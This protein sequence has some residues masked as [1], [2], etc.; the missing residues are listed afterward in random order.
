MVHRLLKFWNIFLPW[1]LKL[2]GQ[3]FLPPGRR[4]VDSPKDI[5][6]FPPFCGRRVVAKGDQFYLP[7]ADT[8]RISAK[9]VFWNTEY[10]KFLERL[11]GIEISLSVNTMLHI[12]GALFDPVMAAYMQEFQGR[13]TLVR[14]MKTILEDWLE[15]EGIRSFDPFDRVCRKQVPRTKGIGVGMSEVLCSEEIILSERDKN[16]PSCQ[17]RRAVL[18]LEE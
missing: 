8:T 12:S 9:L 7:L 2:E 5:A 1:E 15:F 10:E 14:A 11:D 4:V 3:F 13:F 16:L 18:S 17:R 6:L